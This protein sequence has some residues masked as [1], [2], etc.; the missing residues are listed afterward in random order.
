MKTPF[1][2]GRETHRAIT[3]QFGGPVRFR[4]RHPRLHRP[5]ECAFHH[6]GHSIP[7]QGETRRA[8]TRSRQHRTTVA[9]TRQQS[10][11]DP[12]QN[13]LSTHV[14]V[15]EFVP[16]IVH[17]SILIHDCLFV[18]RRF[19]AD[20]LIYV[21]KEAKDAAQSGT[22]VCGVWRKTSCQEREGRRAK[23]PCAWN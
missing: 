5:I 16:Y 7:G 12:S 20:S 13:P 14:A 21:V 4:M 17:T 9:S 15:P 11:N 22:L 18:R 10:S 19:G 6:W 3:A 2:S 8:R 23:C 1:R